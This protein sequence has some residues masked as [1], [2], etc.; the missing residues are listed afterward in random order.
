MFQRKLPWQRREAPP[1]K[2]FQQELAQFPAYSVRAPRYRAVP[3]DHIVGSVNRF[4]DFDR[5]FRPRQDRQMWDTPVRVDRL[6]SLIR[7]G[8]DLHSVL[9]YE[10]NGEY[11]V[12]DGHHR[13]M[14]AKEL[15]RECVDATVKEVIPHPGRKA[16]QE[17]AA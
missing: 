10:L 14:V 6:K 5:G 3:I 12:E 9:L 8:K 1:L 11:Y 17:A 2:S 15:G 13:V 16:S 7:E 4:R